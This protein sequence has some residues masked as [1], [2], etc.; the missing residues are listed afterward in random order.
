[1]TFL[2]NHPFHYF[3]FHISRQF[4]TAQH[5]ILQF[6]RLWEEDRSGAFVTP[7]KT[8]PRSKATIQEITT[9]I[10]NAYKKFNASIDHDDNENKEEQDDFTD[11]RRIQFP[12]CYGLGRGGGGVSPEMDLPTAPIGRGRAPR[13]PR[14]SSS[15]SGGTPALKQHRP[16]SPLHTSTP[17]DSIDNEQFVDAKIQE[18]NHNNHAMTAD[19]VV[20]K[21]QEQRPMHDDL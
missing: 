7:R 13:R 17:H 8:T 1:M 16:T 21:E 6:K 18:N 5:G 12:K 4:N 20:I 10:S 19:D 2:T 15:S 14:P 11:D 3:V 9:D